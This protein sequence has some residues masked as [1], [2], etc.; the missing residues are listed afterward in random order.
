MV[1]QS[2]R[3]SAY[4][5][6]DALFKFGVVGDL[7]DGQLVHRFM[8]ARDGA[9]QAAFAALVKRHGPMVLGVCRQVL[10]DAD[11][12][13]DAFQATFLVLAR[14]AGSLRKADSVACWLHGVALRIAMRARVEAARRRVHE[15]RGAAFP[16]SRTA[17]D[18][19]PPESWPALHEEIDRLPD[20]YRDPIVLCYLEGLSTEEAA[21]RIG[22]PRGTV[23]SRLS[24]ARD[25]LRDRLTRRG[26][27]PGLMPFA[28]GSKPIVLA[29]MPTPLLN[30]TVG[31]A[32]VFAGRRA[33]E[34]ALISAA[35]AALARGLLHVMTISRLTILGAV[36]LSCALA[37]GGLKTLGALGAIAA[38]QQPAPVAP[39]VD[40]DPRVGLTRSVERIQ[41]EV[42]ATA[43]R[44][45]EL[46]KDL[47]RIRAELDAFRTVSWP[48]VSKQAVPRLAGL[49]EPTAASAVADLVGALKRHPPR[50]GARGEDT[51]QLYL[52]DLVAG[53]ETLFVDEVV[54]GKTFAGSAKWSHDG[55]RIVFDATPGMNWQQSHLM[56]LEIR[57]GRP[58][59]TDLGPGNCPT[60]SRDDKRIAFLLNPG[61]VAPAQAG[62]WVMQS[63]GSERTQVSGEY[64][65]PFWSADGGEFLINRFSEPTVAT[66]NNLEA[67]KAGV[68]RVSGYHLYSWP[69]WTG[70][71]QL[72]A[73]LGTGNEADMIALLDVRNPAEAKII[74]V[75]WQRGPDLDV[76]PQRPLYSPESGRCFFVGIAAGNR[77]TLYSVKRGDS[78]QAMRIEPGGISELVVLDFSPDGRY[79]I[80]GGNWPEPR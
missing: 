40:D 9:D 12:A 64:G 67:A 42:D 16:A 79:L 7:S 74:N 31:D 37:V 58:S 60:F 62:I 14:K 44:T 52:L 24:R 38:G 53:G 35:P 46:K 39:E 80:F 61:A 18:P 59:F 68:V 72:V 15:R 66:V 1:T 22:C 75:L 17:A 23:L 25:R 3:A 20:R 6:L 8:T 2:A 32:L 5:R 11:D 65:A 30:A 41:A 70:P 48:A 56:M 54:P 13:Q 51:L 55:R 78:G 77:R 27:A 21:L 73:C 28:A 47:Q 10:H 19:A 57:D 34:A 69:R 50:P 4:D 49:L 33:T 63:N 36:A 76:L 26:L 29:A 71:G 43:R 45:D